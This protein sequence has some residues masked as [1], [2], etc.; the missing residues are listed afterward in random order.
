MFVFRV[1]EAVG[2]DDKFDANGRVCGVE[3]NDGDKLVVLD[4]AVTGVEHVLLEDA[5]AAE[6]V[7]GLNVVSMLSLNSAR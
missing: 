2:V 7:L 4:D 1:V 6:G 3:P 5:A